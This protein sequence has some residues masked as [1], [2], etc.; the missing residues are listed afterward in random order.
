MNRQNFTYI[1][2]CKCGDEIWMSKSKMDWFREDA[3][4]YFHCV[5]GHPQHFSNSSNDLDKLR[6]ERDR[7]KQNKA[8]LED[9]ATNAEKMAK[10]EKRKAS[11]R[12]GQITR[13]KNRAA[14][15]VCPCCNRS[16]ENL[17]RHMSS[18]H[19]KFTAE[20]VV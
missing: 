1:N 6:R 19:P 15:G 16:F 9:R 18:Q 2:C 8:Y 17:K 4:R 5:S 11:A 14:A 10:A 12:K 13:M 3:R 20:E 7:L